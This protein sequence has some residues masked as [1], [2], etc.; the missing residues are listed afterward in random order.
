M[1]AERAN[2]PSRVIPYVTYTLLGL[3]V[4]IYLWDRGGGLFGP[5]VSFADLA[6]R[7]SEVVR[8]VKGNGYPPALGTLF[9]SLFLHGNFLHLLSNMIFLGTFGGEVEE[10]FGSFKFML[11]YLFWGV[12]ACLAHVL[13]MPHSSTP[14]LG[15]SG[16][17]GGILGCYFL[18]YP[19][20]VITVA[21]LVVTFDV[22]AWILLG[23]WFLYQILVPQDGVANWA[24]VGG[25]LA[26]M[27]S[28]LILGGKQRILA[29]LNAGEQRVA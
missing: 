26:G 23:L 28:V 4:F 18:L 15:A 3:N 24:H 19:A 1:I 20:N 8:A 22:A 27:L 5:S 12:F 21:I 9:T 6:M 25:F 11:L 10:A 2:E 16:A 13:V 29:N 14:L 17:I 7:P